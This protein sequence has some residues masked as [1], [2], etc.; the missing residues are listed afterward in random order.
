MASTKTAQ[1]MNEFVANID[2]SKTYSNIEINKVLSD[3]YYKFKK[4][5][6]DGGASDKQIE[7]SEEETVKKNP[8]QYNRYMQSKMAEIK[9]AQPELSAKERMKLAAVE[10]NKHKAGLLAPP[11]SPEDT[12]ITSDSDND[13]EKPKKIVKKQ[14]KAKTSSS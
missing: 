14:P 12:E 2:D 4:E 3:A 9:I 13:K 7:A 5:E 8:S 11:A 10:W 6:K 1:I